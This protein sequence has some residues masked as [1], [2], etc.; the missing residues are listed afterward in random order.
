MA[1]D[2]RSL[3]GVIGGR[4]VARLRIYN[5]E[6][7]RSRIANFSKKKLIIY[8]VDEDRIAIYIHTN[9]GRLSERW[10]PAKNGNNT[11]ILR[12]ALIFNRF[13][14]GCNLSEHSVSCWRQDGLFECGGEDWWRRQVIWKH[15]ER[16]EYS[17]WRVCSGFR[18]K[19]I[20]YTVWTCW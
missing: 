15:L 17:S 19:F 14:K 3:C 2:E 9:C 13:R 4:V 20:N 1:A 10:L 11:Q 6:L 7:D 5:F 18:P 12:W 8:G 16:L